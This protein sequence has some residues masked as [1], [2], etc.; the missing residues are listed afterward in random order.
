M[1]FF[2]KVQVTFWIFLKRKINKKNTKRTTRKKKGEKD[3]ICN[4]SLCYIF[5][6]RKNNNASC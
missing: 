2:L 5:G 1:K 6:G 3:P 4:F